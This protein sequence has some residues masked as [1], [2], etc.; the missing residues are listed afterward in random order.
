MSNEYFIL[1]GREVLSVSMTTW[2]RWY[3]THFKDRVVKQEDVGAFWVSTVFLG[4]NYQWGDGPPLVFET[5]VFRR[6]PD[7]EVDMCEAWGKRC[8]TYD[9]AE[10][11]HRRG[12]EWARNETETARAS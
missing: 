11:Q 10:D 4:T 1:E 7:G 6:K 12:C 3:E 8:S 2:S 5:Y 9:Q